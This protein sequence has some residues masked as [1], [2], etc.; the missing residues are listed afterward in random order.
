MTE[1]ETRDD[2]SRKAKSKRYYYVYQQRLTRLSY[3][4]FSIINFIIYV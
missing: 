4:L 2:P 3:Q 1:A